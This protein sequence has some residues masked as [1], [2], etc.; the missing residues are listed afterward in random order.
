MALW[1]ALA[2]C[3]D[4][5]VLCHMRRDVEGAQIGHMIG[6][7]RHGV[8]YVGALLAQQTHRDAS[9]PG[10]HRERT[11]PA[12]AHVLSSGEHLQT[13][14]AGVNFSAQNQSFVVNDNVDTSLGST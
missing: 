1:A 4:A 14:I 6:G 3:G 10:L 9:P 13:K 2:G 5:V 12:A 7:V 11:H 8:Q